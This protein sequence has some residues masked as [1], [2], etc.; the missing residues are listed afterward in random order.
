MS[1]IWKLGV[2]ATLAFAITGILMFAAGCGD[3][4]GGS[5][6]TTGAVVKGPVTG[7][8]VTDA[9]GKTATTGPDGRFS[10]DNATGGFTSHLGIYVPIRELLQTWR[11]PLVQLT[12]LH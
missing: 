12:S 10:I 2:R 4:D 1:K 5:T 11:H 6:V 8:T 3:D 7:A 9:S